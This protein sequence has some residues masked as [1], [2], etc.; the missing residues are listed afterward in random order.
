MRVWCKHMF[1]G[2]HKWRKNTGQLKCLNIRGL[3]QLKP[4]RKP[5]GLL[6][7]IT[8]LKRQPLNFY[9]FFFFFSKF[10]F[11]SYKGTGPV[12]VD[13]LYWREKCRH[14]L[15]DDKHWSRVW[16]KIA[17]TESKKAFL[18][19]WQQSAEQSWMQN[20]SR[21]DISHLKM[22]SLDQRCIPAQIKDG[23]H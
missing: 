21:A 6:L 3:E 19:W 14:L 2:I 13:A 10:K 22:V 1:V 16:S 18:N 17:A 11:L 9:W 5:T 8:V 23:F 12:G 4:D 15:L 7:P 20:F